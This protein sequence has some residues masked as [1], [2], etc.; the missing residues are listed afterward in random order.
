MKPTRILLAVFVAA[1]IQ[2]LAGCAAWQ[3]QGWE[4]TGGWDMSHLRDARA[5]EL[6]SRLASRPAPV[7]SP[8]TPPAEA[9]AA[10]SEV[11]ASQ[12]TASQATA[13]EAAYQN[14]AAE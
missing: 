9:E 11:A 14:A 6:D 3:S 12:A 10:E 8:F 5:A 13:S 1:G 4:R 2:C 7:Q